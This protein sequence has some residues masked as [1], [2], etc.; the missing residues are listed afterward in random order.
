MFQIQI[1]DEKK[2]L[3][4]KYNTLIKKISSKIFNDEKLEGD[5]IFELHIIENNQSWEI[6]RKYR[7]KDY[8]TD[9]ISFSFWEA[10][11][12]KTP[13]LGEI[14]LNIDKVHEQ[15]K[16]YNHSFDRELCFLVSHGI[17]HLLGYDH[18]NDAE[19][20][21]M[22]SKQYNV[23]NECGLGKNTDFIE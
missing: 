17:F 19:A 15:S 10:N 5:I 20:K 2:L 1:N 18:E 7:N 22:F 8:P 4:K 6:N 16:E 13:L 9:V 23:L 14:F 11:T 12:I 21:I 3:D